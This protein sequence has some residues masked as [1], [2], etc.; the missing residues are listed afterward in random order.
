MGSD[1]KL[2]VGVVLYVMLQVHYIFV[3][4]LLCIC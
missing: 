4:L 3:T 2:M 1:C